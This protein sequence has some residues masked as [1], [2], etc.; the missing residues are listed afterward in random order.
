MY[1]YI[2]NVSYIQKDIQKQRRW[3]GFEKGGHQQVQPRVTMIMLCIT[4]NVFNPLQ[5]R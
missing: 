5:L 2:Y 3:Y 4:K 1:T